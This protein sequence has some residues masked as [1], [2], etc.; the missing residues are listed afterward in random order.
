MD[1]FLDNR[2]SKL[3]LYIIIINLF[4]N[5]NKIKEVRHRSQPMAYMGNPFELAKQNK[6]NKK[7]PTCLRPTFDP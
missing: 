2:F 1:I 4:K 5:N 6:Q 7:C 3:D